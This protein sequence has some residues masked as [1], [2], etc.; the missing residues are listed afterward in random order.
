MAVS[1]T[2]TVDR[3]PERTLRVAPP[4]SRP[5]RVKR[6]KREAGGKSSTPIAMCSQHRYEAD[7]GERLISGP[8]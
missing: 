4:V 6:R 8:D 1:S 3:R 2:Y 5:R 7:R